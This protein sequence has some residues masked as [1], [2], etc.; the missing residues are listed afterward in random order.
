MSDRTS[1]GSEGFGCPLPSD[2]SG[3]RITLA[4]GEGGRLSRRLIQDHI[5][6]RF[7]CPELQALG[8]A[9]IVTTSGGPLA[10]TTDGYTVTPLFFPGGDIGQL[11]VFGTVNDLAVSGAL[12]R[13]LSVSLII[14][15]GAAV[16]CTGPRLGKFA[17]R[18][19]TR[20]GQDRDRRHQGCASGNRRS[21][22]HYHFGN[23]RDS[24]A[25]SPPAPPPFVPHDCLIVS[26]PIG[27]HGAAVLCAREGFDFD[28]APQSD[29][30]PLIEPLMALYHANC[31]PRATRDATRGGVAAVLQE[32]SEASQRTCTIEADAIPV[33]AQVRAVCELLGLDPLHLANEGT[34]VLASNSR[35]GRTH[36]E[37]PSTA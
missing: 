27:R 22:L 1:L 35:L 31:S 2:A 13:W 20:Q 11:A 4:H 5:L 36:I 14:E 3:E 9:A 18:G 6:P 25:R 10:F 7:G 29:C 37:R 34:F 26:G 8:D 32:W 12:P 19:D 16:V 15:E 17:G 30:A 24:R 33:E 28:P 21:T 23:R